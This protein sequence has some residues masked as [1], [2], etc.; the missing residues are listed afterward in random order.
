MVCH[1]VMQMLNLNK[2]GSLCNQVE[3]S[4]DKFCLMA[5]RSPGPEG[6]RPASRLGGL[7]A[8]AFPPLFCSPHK[9]LTQDS[10]RGGNSGPDCPD[11]EDS[12]VVPLTIGTSHR[13]SC[14]RSQ[15]SRLASFPSQSPTCA[16]ID[17]YQM[18]LVVWK[19]IFNQRD[20]HK[21][22]HH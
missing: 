12:G 21:S 13:F 5:A 15:N 6:R 9:V 7:K 20:F 8:Y 10:R 16:P 3:H 22:R 14:Y 19:L 2:G 4:A 11:M 17:L 1:R 18:G